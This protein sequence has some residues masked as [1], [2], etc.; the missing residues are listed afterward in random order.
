M[1]TYYICLWFIVASYFFFKDR[2]IDLYSVV[3]FT[4]SYYSY[5]LFFGFLYDPENHTYPNIDTRIYLYYMV[6]FICLLIGAW[7]RDQHPIRFQRLRNPIPYE[8][9]LLSLV[10]LC[11]ILALY[12]DFFVPSDIDSPSRP[13][14][15]GP[16]YPLYVWSSLG[17]FWLA[18][19]SRSKVLPWVA[20]I[21]IVLTT[22]AG[23]RSFFAVLILAIIVAGSIQVADN[24][25]KKYSKTKHF[26][27]LGISLVVMILYKVLYMH[28]L[29]GDLNLILTVLTDIDSIVFRLVEGSEP[30][31]VMM[32]MQNSLSPILD[33]H[34]EYRH[35][36][37]I[38]SV[39]FFSNL[40]LD[41]MGHTNLSF[42][43]VLDE[44]FYTTVNYGM[45][46][47]LVGELYYVG[48]YP[49]VLF[50]ILIFNFLLYHSNDY[51][52]KHGG[53]ATPALIWIFFFYH[54]LELKHLLYVVFV[55]AVCAML[56]YFLRAML[57]SGENKNVS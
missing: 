53:W 29:T 52:F 6:Y 28:I 35:L 16:I 1:A 47:T 17:L 10:F 11:A 14:V 45:A 43:D 27:F 2:K 46:S 41:L 33:L 30:Y 18:L 23:G 49:L 55:S 3:F 56:A 5:P 21:F 50:F 25:V 4:S 13:S 39:P 51:I 34:D 57:S 8:W 15:L 54:R 32:N 44:N 36:F 9:L 42:S 38:G 48:G 37:F 26:L 22:F 19:F 12:P 20:A 31:L 40:F 7:Y 24:G